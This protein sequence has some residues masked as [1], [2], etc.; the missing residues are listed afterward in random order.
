MLPLSMNPPARY[1]ER[2]ISES[3]GQWYIAKVKSRQEKALAFDLIKMKIEYYLPMYTKVTRR[4]DNNKPRKSILC[5]FPGYVS[6]CIK[7]SI[8]T[9]L[10]A[11]NRVVTLVKIN[12]QK[13]FIKQL[14]Q[15]YK[16]YNLGVQLK[17]VVDMKD[18]AL[19]KQVQVICGPMRGLQGTISKVQKSH[20]LILSV[21]SLGKVSVNID[22]AFVKTL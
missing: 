8:E 7:E 22:A 17:P 1:P 16:A 20:K 3:E 11:T 19:G 12:N 18:L 13:L 2:Q 10:Y 14:D 15:V 21:D 6:F 9:D 5:L 4:R